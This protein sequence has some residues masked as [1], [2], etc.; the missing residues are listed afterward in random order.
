MNCKNCGEP[1]TTGTGMRYKG[2]LLHKGCVKEIK[3]IER[4]DRK[5]ERERDKRTFDTSELTKCNECRLF[6]RSKS[7]CLRGDY[8][9]TAEDISCS[10]FEVR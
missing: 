2:C 5:L 8:P 4:E 9:S 1:I 7:R 3:R 10:K 6:H